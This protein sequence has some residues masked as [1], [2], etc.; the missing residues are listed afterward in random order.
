MFGRQQRLGLNC[1][2]GRGME[3]GLGFGDRRGLNGGSGFGRGRGMGRGL[4]RGYGMMAQVLETPEQE[5]EVLE[6][7]AG[8]LKQDMEQVNKRIAELKEQPQ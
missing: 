2:Q 7:I 8:C 3:C 5:I 1:R 6:R 4:G